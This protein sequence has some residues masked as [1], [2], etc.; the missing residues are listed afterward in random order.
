MP[1][2]LQK[3]GQGAILYPF[4]PYPQNRFKLFNVPPDRHL[5]GTN[6][7]QTAFCAPVMRHI[8]SVILL[9]QVVTLLTKA[10]ILVQNQ[11]DVICFISASL[12]IGISEC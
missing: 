11:I 7:N 3:G 9:V 10:D 12:E 4:I 8:Q 5:K 6:L 2:G 1:P